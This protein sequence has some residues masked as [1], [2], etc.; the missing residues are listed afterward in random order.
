M[1]Y[2]RLCIGLALPWH[3]YYLFF[4]CADLALRM[5]DDYGFGQMY[6]NTL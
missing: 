1:V 6:D 5:I 3:V 2:G 4:L